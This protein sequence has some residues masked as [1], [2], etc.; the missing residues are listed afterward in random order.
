MR[1][2]TEKPTDARC[3]RHYMYKCEHPLYSECT[4]L[5]M[6]GK[7]LAVVQKR[8]NSKLKVF[9]YGPIDSWLADLIMMQPGFEA[10]FEEHSGYGE[11]YIYPTVTVRQI[12]WALKMKPLR[13]SEWES[14][15]LQLL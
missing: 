14:Q 11:D 12:M 3:T 15:E 6:G 2:Y 10:Y 13:K 8:F 4:L 5:Q 1:Y 9:W 7:G